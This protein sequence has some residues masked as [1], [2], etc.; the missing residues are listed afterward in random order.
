MSTIN[1]LSLSGGKDSTAMALLAI[2]RETENMQAVFCDTGNEHP[3]T[4]DYVRYL[5]D[6]LGIDIKWIK[7]DLSEKINAKRDRLIADA[8]PQRRIDAMRPTGN[9]FLDLCI[10]K[11]RFPASQSRFCTI[12]LKR[13]VIR[14]QVY[15]PILA[16]GEDIEAWQ[17]IR[18]DESKSRSCAVEHDFAFADEKTGAEVWNYRPILSWTAED[19][20]EIMRRHGIK[21]N[22]LYKLG[23]GRVGCMPCVN[24]RKSELAEISARFPE[25]IDRIESWEKVV[26]DAGNR[27]EATF[28]P[29]KGENGALSKGIRS[30]VEWSKTD[31]GGR[32]FSLFDDW[33]ELPACSS[34]YGLCEI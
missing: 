24:C 16:T 29:W 6:A 10:L 28:F 22:P 32:Q 31:R 14:S 30:A 4:Y 34:A 7:A 17:G 33:E 9:P 2:E 27:G 3:M 8:A 18:W 1:V 21:P 5:S 26:S 20:F 19:T 11:G 23:M 25:V 13:D 15:E 12:E